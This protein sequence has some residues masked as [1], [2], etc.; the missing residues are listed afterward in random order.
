MQE[1][2]GLLA[3]AKLLVLADCRHTRYSDSVGVKCIQTLKFFSLNNTVAETY[4]S[5]WQRVWVQVLRD[6]ML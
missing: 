1:S 6:V 4:T 3:I 5:I 2:C